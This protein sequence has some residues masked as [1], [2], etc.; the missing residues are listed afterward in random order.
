[1]GNYEDLTDEIFQDLL[2]ELIHD[3]NAGEILAVPGVY[4]AMSEELNN[5]VLDLFEQK[6]AENKSINQ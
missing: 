6:Q 4:E 5:N 2:E 1:M 3:M